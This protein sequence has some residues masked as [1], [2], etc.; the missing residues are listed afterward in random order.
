MSFTAEDIDVWFVDLCDADWSGASAERTLTDDERARAERFRGDVR[1]RRFRASRV[2][3]RSILASHLGCVAASLRFESGPL[4]KPRLASGMSEAGVEFNLSHSEDVAAIAVAPRTP[5]GVDIECWREM[6]ELEGLAA[7]FFTA[8]EAAVLRRAAPSDRLQT[9][10]RCWTRK[11]ACIKAWG[12][13]F[14]IGLHTF[15]VH[16]DAM[17]PMTV[18]RSGDGY[19]VLTVIDLLPPPGFSTAVAVAGGAGRV[20]STLVAAGT[21]VHDMVTR[22]PTPEVTPGTPLRQGHDSAQTDV[23]R[24]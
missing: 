1:R 9:F 19:G 16:A 8:A 2:A 13:S 18:A 22:T 14:S 17:T 11:E 4:G 20:T 10:Y 12:T 6:P 5:V 24:A 15:D 21:R 3:L 7:R 23:R